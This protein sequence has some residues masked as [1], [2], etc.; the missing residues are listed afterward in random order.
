MHKGCIINQKARA[1]LTDLI[2]QNIIAML[3]LPEGG[4][5]GGKIKEEN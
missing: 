1:N 4:F 2:I 5:D 3:L